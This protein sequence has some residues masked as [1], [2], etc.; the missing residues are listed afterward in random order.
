M[1]GHVYE[2]VYSHVS[3]HVHRHRHVYGHVY[4]HV[5]NGHRHAYRYRQHKHSAVLQQNTLY[6][7]MRIDMCID[8]RTDMRTDMCVDMFDSAWAWFRS[9]I[10]AHDAATLSPTSP[11]RPRPFKSRHRAVWIRTLRHNNVRRAKHV[12]DMRTHK[13]L[14][15]ASPHTCS[16]TYLHWLPIH[17]ST[18]V[19]EYQRYI[20]TLFVRTACRHHISTSHID[21]TCR[22]HISTTHVDTTSPPHVGPTSPHHISAHPPTPHIDTT[23][24]HHISTAQVDNTCR[25]TPPRAHTT[26]HVRHHTVTSHDRAPVLMLH[27]VVMNRPFRIRVHCMCALQA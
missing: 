6:V 16:R 2:H 18:H 24:P 13:H 17:M 21:T 8:M 3:R 5:C 14:A 1:K 23:C 25:H 11:T 19:R 20:S 22:H 12:F 10:P 4:G 9:N 15:H 27:Q 26:T 7:G